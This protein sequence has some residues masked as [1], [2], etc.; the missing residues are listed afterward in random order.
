MGY[1]N[2]VDPG[3]ANKSLITRRKP[4]RVTGPG[5]NL[6]IGI[7]EW[8]IHSESNGISDYGMYRREG[9]ERHVQ[10]AGYNWRALELSNW[11]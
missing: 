7:L 2:K 3:H 5:P 11:I 10:G 9:V 1:V 4:A 8:S 6:Y